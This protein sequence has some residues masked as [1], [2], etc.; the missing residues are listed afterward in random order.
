MKKT[1]I[2]ERKKLLEQ[3]KN[4]E[5]RVLTEELVKDL[6]E[7]LKKYLSVCGYMNTS[8]DALIGHQSRPHNDIDIFIQKKDTSVFV[9][10]LSSNGYSETKMDYT[11]NDHTAWHDT[12]NRTI[13]PN[14]TQRVVV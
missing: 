5:V 10:M 3:N 14:K 13:E 7:Q 1:Y 11:T 8:I 12:N 9:E 4:S 2:K 6:P